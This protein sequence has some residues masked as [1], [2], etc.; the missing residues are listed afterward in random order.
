MIWH[1]KFDDHGNEWWE[2]HSPYY[3]DRA[4]LFWRLKQRLCDNRI[5]WYA[6]HDA[7]LGGDGETWT[8]LEEAKAAVEQAHRN[9]LNE[10]EST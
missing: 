3:C 4:P 2:A 5:E 6:D 1:Q 10:I 9:V 7:E 8:S